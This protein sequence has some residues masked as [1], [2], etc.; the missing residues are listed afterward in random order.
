MEATSPPPCSHTSQS[1]SSNVKPVRIL[2]RTSCFMK[3]H[4]LKHDRDSSTDKDAVVV[5]LAYRILSFWLPLL[6]RLL[7]I[8]FF[9]RQKGERH[10]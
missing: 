4:R 1:T 3:A 9:P 8:L 5:V 2:A 7:L 10:P 6:F